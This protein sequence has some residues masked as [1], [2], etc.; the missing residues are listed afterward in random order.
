MGKT[1]IRKAITTLN[2]VEWKDKLHLQKKNFFISR[3][4]L[5]LLTCIGCLKAIKENIIWYHLIAFHYYF[6]IYKLL[7][8][9]IRKLT[10][11]WKIKV[12][13]RY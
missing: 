11:L 5:L 6:F 3:F 1:F 8:N 13:F 12:F 10:I 7:K 4:Y 9:T 2:E